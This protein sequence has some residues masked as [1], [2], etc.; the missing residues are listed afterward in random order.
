MVRIF[1][2]SEGYQGY[3]DGHYV[4]EIRNSAFVVVS[5]D[6]DLNKDYK[7][8]QN[9]AKDAGLDY[10]DDDLGEFVLIAQ[11]ITVFDEPEIREPDY[12]YD[13]L[14]LCFEGKYVGRTSAEVADSAFV[15]AYVAI[16]P[17]KKNQYY[18]VQTRL[19]FDEYQALTFVL[20]EYLRKEA[21]VEVA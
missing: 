3:E 10:E 16:V 6:T 19:D 1:K 5:D 8:L 9:A 18:P 21:A 15:A 14:S 4:S 20:G 11:A 7:A 12:L 2:I 17:L 13:C